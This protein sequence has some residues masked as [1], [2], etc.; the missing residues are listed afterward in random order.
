MVTDME[1][2]LHG[3][4]PARHQAGDMITFEKADGLRWIVTVLGTAEDGDMVL[5]AWDGLPHL[6]YA[7]E[8][9]LDRLRIIRV[10]RADTASLAEWRTMLKYPAGFEPVE[11]RVAA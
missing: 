8:D 1:T 7:S 10:E 9:A 5:M 6:L 11:M 4:N 3:P 2:L